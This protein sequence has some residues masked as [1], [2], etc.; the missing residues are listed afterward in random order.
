VAVCV[1]ST[2]EYSAQGTIEVARQNQ[3]E[4]NLNEM[5]GEQ[6]NGSDA[7]EDNIAI[8]TQA[9]ILQSDTLALKVVHELGLENTSEFSPRK[10]FFARLLGVPWGKSEES[11]TADSPVQQTYILRVFR[12]HLNVRSRAGTRLIDITYSSSNP[13]TAAKVVNRLMKEL[14]DYTFQIHY[15]ATND[16]AHWIADQMDNLKK[17]AQDHQAKVAQLQRDAG[18]Y[19]IGAV[20][21]SGKELAYSATLDRL[22][23]ATQALAQATSNRIL[24]WSIYQMVSNGG[25]DSI[26]GLSGNNL[27]GASSEMNNSFALLQTLRGQQAAIQSQLS[28]DSSKYGSANPKLLDEKASLSSITAAI[29]DEIRRIGRRAEN[30][31]QAAVSTEMS[32]RADYKQQRAAADQLNNKAIE[33]SIAKQEAAQS[34]QLYE[35]LYQHLKEA[36]VVEGLR[37]S[38][39]TVIDPG[40]IPSVASKPN[41]KLTLGM[42]LFAGLFCGVV[43]AYLVDSLDGRLHSI[44]AVEQYL[45]TP[46]LGVIPRA[47]ALESRLGPDDPQPRRYRL[48]KGDKSI[49]R[50]A[51]LLQAP[52]TSTTAFLEALRSLRT[53]I[54]LSRSAA[55]PKVILITS[56]G[57]S[58]G[59]TT[60]SL[61]LAAAL[62]RNQKRVLF[63]EADLRCP[64][65]ADRL[66][67]GKDWGLSTL[68]TGNTEVPAIRPFADLES[69]TV[70]PA[71]PTPPYPAELLGSEQ[72]KTL[73][74]DWS[75]SHDFIVIDSPAVLAVTDAVVLSRRADIVLLVAR[76]AQ[77]T[78]K[79]L[80]RAWRQLT[81]NPDLKVATVL[82]AVSRESVAYQ[83][84]FG[85]R[86][87]RYYGRQEEA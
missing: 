59:K 67:L 32:L 51:L 27:S 58:E 55:P 16:A 39:V 73:I 38:N 43:G 81:P 1:L 78:R 29:N 19:S 34:R 54:L 63:V 12:K 72:M 42:S 52:D 47:P 18:V 62:A 61:H 36:G 49:L 70:I 68:L 5:K 64:K 23:G 87:T 45:N 50:P 69:L 44:E 37:S 2:K 21:G 31:Y 80:E 84:Y 57:E 8:Q 30:D 20:D 4:L 11:I 56:A 79:S 65:I 3:A 10:A 83:E 25:P 75:R 7:L 48:L 14:V 6:A 40:R 60:I 17:E 74:D 85:Y 33:Y 41:Y 22:Q 15:N 53:S 28:A 77:S 46:L 35:T 9:S 82:N 13:E 24:K 66:G 26:S 71:G 86:G 76:H